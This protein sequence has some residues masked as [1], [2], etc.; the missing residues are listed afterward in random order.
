MTGWWTVHCQCRQSERKDRRQ[1][2]HDLPR[3]Q[4]R[5]L[6]QTNGACLLHYWQD[7]ATHASYFI[8]VTA[9]G[10]TSTR[11]VVLTTVTVSSDRICLYSD[12]F[13]RSCL[14]EIVTVWQSADSCYNWGCLVRKLIWHARCVLIRADE[15]I[16]RPLWQRDTVWTDSVWTPNRESGQRYSRQRNTLSE[17]PNW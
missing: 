13:T 17:L 9:A 15:T 5:Q 7:W 2:D 10:W 4:D 14:I 6:T 11:V 16:L 3:H 12:V 8:Y 1:W